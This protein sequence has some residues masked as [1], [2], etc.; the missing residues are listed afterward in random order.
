MQRKQIKVGEFY[1]YTSGTKKY[2]A[3]ERVKIL[4]L[5]HPF[6]V[7]YRKGYGASATEETR[8]E[9]D[10]QYI[11]VGDDGEPK[12]THWRS[13]GTHVA[14]P[15]RLRDVKKILHTWDEELAERNAKQSQAEQDAATRS[16]ERV[17]AEALRFDLLSFLGDHGGEEAMKIRQARV[18]DDYH[19]TTR[20]YLDLGAI[21]GQ[22]LLRLVNAA[23]QAG[24][25]D[26]QSD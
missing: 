14:E 6:E 21:D 25:V 20:S 17:A 1:A 22:R 10:I 2:G 9:P 5:D 4:A 11:V 12:V 13:G 24:R 19:S 8:I 7:V 23:Y 16:A 26:G 18:V 15:Q 3:R